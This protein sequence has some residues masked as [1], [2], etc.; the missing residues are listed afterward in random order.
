LC[1]GGAYSTMGTQ[2]DDTYAR[3][4]LVGS[5]KHSEKFFLRMH[6]SAISL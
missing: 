5:I 1:G 2:S 6:N 4:F 3:L